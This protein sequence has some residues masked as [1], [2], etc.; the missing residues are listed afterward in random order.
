MSINNDNKNVESTIGTNLLE[1]K[2]NPSASNF[3]QRYSST[4]NII[5]ASSV[6][7]A[8]FQQIN[9]NYVPAFYL[10]IYWNVRPCE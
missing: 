10:C 6:K 4:Q 8:Q 7:Y 2:K 9:K 5:L 1:M 3:Q